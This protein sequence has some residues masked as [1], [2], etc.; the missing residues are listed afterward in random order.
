MILAAARE[1]GVDP[2]D[3]AT[4]IRYETARTNDPD[5]KGPTTRWGQHKGLIQWGEPQSRRYGVDQDWSIPNQGRAIVQYLKDAGVKPGM[6]LENIYS[7]VNAGRV[8]RPNASDRPGATVASH[9]AQMTQVDRPVAALQLAGAPDQG[10][11]VWDAVPA[12]ASYAEEASPKRNI[13]DD[14]FGSPGA[15]ATP[16]EDEQ[17]RALLAQ[18]LG[19]G[20]EV[21]APDFDPISGG[22]KFATYRLPDGSRGYFNSKDKPFETYRP[23]FGY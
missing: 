15:A 18:V 10:G 19:D 14:A 17:R 20:A 4:V 9:V 21:S 1:L 8:G 2:V 12:W 7:A 13:F 16:S 5:I 6:G 23:R 3:L 11:G 22:S